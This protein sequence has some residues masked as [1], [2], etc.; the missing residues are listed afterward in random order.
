MRSLYARLHRRYGQRLSGQELARIVR[1]RNEALEQRYPHVRIEKRRGKKAGDGRVIVVGAGF[2]GLMAAAS[3]PPNLEVVLF[4][5]G[6][7]LGGRVHT[8]YDFIPNRIVEAGAE[9]IGASHATW[10]NL[11]RQYDLNFVE[12]QHDIYDAEGLEFPVYLHGQRIPNDQLPYIHEATEEA[13]QQV[14]ADAEAVVDPFQPWSSGCAGEYDSTSLGEKLDQFASTGIVREVLEITYGND[15]VKPSPQQ[16]YLG[17]C[18]LVKAGGGSQFWDLVENF[19]CSQGN[20]ALAEK[21]A[22]SVRGQQNGIQFFRPVTEIR[23]SHDR[24]VVQAGPDRISA[25]Y[26]V[27]AIPQ[28]QWANI[29]IYPPLA[30]QDF[31]ISTG[32]AVKYLS[33][34][35]QRFWR[36]NG[37]AP[38]ASSDELGLT[39]EA[40]ETQ[41]DA[42]GAGFNL[43]VFAGGTAARR[44]EEYRDDPPQLYDPGLDLILPGYLAN[45]AGTSLRDWPAEVW[46]AT[47]YASPSPG[48]APGRPGDIRRCGPNLSVPW[49]NRLIF[50]GEHTCFGFYGFM[51]GALLSGLKASQWVAELVR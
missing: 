41:D 3:M 17:I 14:A 43:S 21:L 47:G 31:M 20:Q 36:A 26:C 46:T 40:T 45:R 25:D 35:S 27:L 7:R 8:L 38:D 42:D 1:Q 44:A 16:S 48:D 33:P 19:R 9:L 4:E 51:E 34:V 12:L 32:P 28:S 49:Q 29:N 50:A 11:A 24:V 10:L 5:A 18:S 13:Q 30:P 39:W 2:A 15:N 37:L 6:D 22:E 23:I